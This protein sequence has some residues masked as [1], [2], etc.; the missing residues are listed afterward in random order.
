MRSSCNSKWFYSPPAN[1]NALANYYQLFVSRRHLADS[2]VVSGGNVRS[3][4][5]HSQ[6][7]PK[8]AMGA[9]EFK[10]LGRRFERISCASG[11]SE[12]CGFVVP[13]VF[14]AAIGISPETGG[15]FATIRWRRSRR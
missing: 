3:K 14:S 11:S 2:G 15:G 1:S 10:T 4:H 5:G 13:T 8:A 6:S 12:S 7:P 9:V